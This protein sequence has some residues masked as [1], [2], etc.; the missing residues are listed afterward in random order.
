MIASCM[1]LSLSQLI[2]SRKQPIETR[3]IQGILQLRG[4][5]MQCIND[6]LND[7]YRA[8][9]DH[10]IVATLLLATCE[11]LH[12]LR[13]SYPIHMIGL[14]DMVNHRGGLRELG[15]EGCVEAF[16]KSLHCLDATCL[17]RCKLISI[18]TVLWQDANIAH[19]VGGQTYSHLAKNKSPLPD[20]KV[21]KDHFL[22]G[23]VLTADTF[24]E[25]NE[26]KDIPT[27]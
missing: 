8:A 16:S 7:K 19:I 3:I 24:A 12:G 9:C 21:D 15:F 23:A 26:G 4:Y 22:A 11:A 17:Q 14:M 5:V 13:E 10:V 1:L 6:A 2:A 27:W 18:T 25:E 20:A